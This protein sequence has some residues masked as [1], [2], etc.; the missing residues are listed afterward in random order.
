MKTTRLLLIS[1]AIP[2][3]I[4]IGCGGGALPKKVEEPKKVE[5]IPTKASGSSH[6]ELL[7]GL[8]DQINLERVEGKDMYMGYTSDRTTGGKQFVSLI[9][10]GP[11]EAAYRAFLSVALSDAG[12]SEFLQRNQKLLDAFLQNIFQGN[13]PE[14]L[15]KELDTAQK[16]P[17][18]ERKFSVGDRNVKIKCDLT[19]RM[20][21]DVQ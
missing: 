4:L 7:K 13:V 14:I 18:K 8:S 10:Y 5:T 15:K 6:A 20:T 12:N 21:I 9:I 19:Q 11:P 1:G 16:T 2:A 3:L 17:D